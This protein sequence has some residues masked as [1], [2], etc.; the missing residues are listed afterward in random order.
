M[1]T[2]SPNPSNLVLLA[3]IGIGAYWVMSRRAVAG[4]AVAP[5]LG[6]SSPNVNA[7]LS[8]ASQFLGGLSSMFGGQ[9][10][11]STGSAVGV[12]NEYA[13]AAV[14]SGDPYYGSSAVD[15]LA[16]NPPTGGSLYDMLV[17]QQASGTIDYGQ[18][19]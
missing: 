3:A 15:G 8:L 12:P 10:T 19:F 2:A 7:G 17:A 18:F 13:R 9:A 1:S 5:R 16:A 6:T 11:D 4:T 14:R